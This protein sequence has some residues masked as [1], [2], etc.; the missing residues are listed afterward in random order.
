[1]KLFWTE[2]LT[3]ERGI[4]ATS[5][6]VAPKGM[7]VVVSN[8]VWVVHCSLELSVISTL[9]NKTD[10]QCRRHCSELGS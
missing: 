6:C 8:R 5:V 2:V 4:Q 10:K 3:I 7:A 1:M 9:P